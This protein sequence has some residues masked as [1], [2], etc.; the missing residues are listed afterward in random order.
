MNV[1]QAVSNNDIS[2]LKKLINGSKSDIDSKNIALENASSRGYLDMVEFLI[3][4]GAYVK[5]NDNICLKVA[6]VKGHLEVVKLLIEKGA[7][8][9]IIND[10]ELTNE[11]K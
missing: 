5:V 8:L 6:C 1:L 9:N 3:E 11:M 7:K 2:L 10:S 4:K